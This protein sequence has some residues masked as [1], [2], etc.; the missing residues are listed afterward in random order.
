MTSSTVKDVSEAAV[1]TRK[2]H[3]V[4]FKSLHDSFLSGPKCRDVVPSVLLLAEA[5]A[6]Q[7][8]AEPLASMNGAP[9]HSSSP[10]CVRTSDFLSAADL[11][12]PSC[13][14][15]RKITPANVEVEH[16]V[17]LRPRAYMKL[18]SGKLVPVKGATRHHCSGRLVKKGAQAGVS[19][20]G[21]G[22]GTGRGGEGTRRGG[23]GAGRRGEGA[24]RGVEGTR[25]GGEGTRRGGEGPGRGGGVKRAAAEEAMRDASLVSVKVR[26]R[27][28]EEALRQWWIVF[29]S[30]RV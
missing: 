7:E 20:L 12:A 14:P 24:G 30:L 8:A 5:A 22:E 23:E 10:V 6:A 1:L 2:R 29:S 9:L 11:P 13:S 21:G 26:Y 4:R 3:A 16:G 28:T 17:S 18:E 25:R 19:H 15:G 27:K